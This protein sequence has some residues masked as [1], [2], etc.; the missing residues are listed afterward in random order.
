MHA[1][2]RA[3]EVVKGPLVGEAG[4]GTRGGSHRSR[5][6]QIIAYLIRRQGTV[7]VLNMLLCGKGCQLKPDWKIKLTL[8][9]RGG[10][11]RGF[12]VD[13][14]VYFLLLP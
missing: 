4:G 10:R 3:G 9:I 14:K 7:L 11:G 12:R 5:F 13:N 2:S 6:L 1:V 8:L